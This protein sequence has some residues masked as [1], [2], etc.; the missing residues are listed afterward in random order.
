MTV[1]PYEIHYASSEDIGKSDV[2]QLFAGETPAVGTVDV[3]L[4]SGAREQ[5]VPLGTDYG[6]WEAGQTITGVTAYKV[7]GGTREA[8]Y[9]SGCFNIDA[10]AWPAGTTEAQVQAGM[11]LSQLKFRKLLYS[12]KRTGTEP[13]PGGEAGPQTT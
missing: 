8:I 6:A 10:I 1:H 11:A 12:D 5:F 7:P 9:V 2:P 3:L 4:P 13:A